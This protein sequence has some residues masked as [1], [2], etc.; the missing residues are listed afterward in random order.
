MEMKGGSLCETGPGRR[1]GMRC[2][3]GAWRGE[4]D[5]GTGSLH[6]KREEE[7]RAGGAW[8]REGT[9]G[10]MPMVV[11]TMGGGSSSEP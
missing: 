9:R 5:D 3:G 4:R 6:D 11:A 10:R 7:G 8:G 1:G 2:W